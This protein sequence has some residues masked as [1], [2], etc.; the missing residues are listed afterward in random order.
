MLYV[1][2]VP[3]RERLLRVLMGL[4]LLAAAILWLGANING[5]AA[6]ATGMMAALT[7][8]IGWCPMCAV[9][10]RKPDAGH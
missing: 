2:N 7:G 3:T 1:K 9:A 8:L 5:F 4:A 6:G 10:G